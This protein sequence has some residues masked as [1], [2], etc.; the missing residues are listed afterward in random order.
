MPNIDTPQGI[1]LG[2]RKN[3]VENK[4]VVIKWNKKHIILKT[5]QKSL[6]T[7]SSLETSHVDCFER[8]HQQWS[9][10][11][12]LLSVGYAE[13]EVRTERVWTTH[14]NPVIITSQALIKK[15]TGNVSRI[16]AIVTEYCK[17]WN[18]AEGLFSFKSF[19][20]NQCKLKSLLTPMVDC[21]VWQP[22]ARDLKSNFEFKTFQPEKVRF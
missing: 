15:A 4:I 3:Y 1:R 16:A 5:A 6:D 11:E 7:H 17:F 22:R 14:N 9:S 10:W 19:W 2:S 21:R 18:V 13:D 12:W 20:K 8:Q